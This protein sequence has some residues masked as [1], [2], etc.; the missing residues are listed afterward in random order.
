MENEPSKEDY[1]K[2]YQDIKSAIEDY[3][4]LYHDIKSAIEQMDSGFKIVNVTLQALIDKMESY[5][6][7][8]ASSENVTDIFKVFFKYKWLLALILLGIYTLL[9]NSTIE[10]WI[11][12]LF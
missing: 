1:T 8:L 9:T 11:G 12:R 7:R 5:D 4:K 3:T 10:K 2:L 6:T